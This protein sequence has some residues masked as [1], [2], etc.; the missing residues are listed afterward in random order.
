MT[1]VAQT[2]SLLPRVELMTVTPAMATNWLE[3]A[4]T[5]NRKL[6]DAYV[7]RLARDIA[8]GRWLLT[9]EGLAFDPT[10]VLLDGQHRLWAVV[11][12]DK[13]IQTYVWLNITPDALVAINN[14]RPRSIQDALTLAGGMG[15]VTTDEMATLRALLGGLGSPPKL[16]SG[17]AREALVRHRAAVAF[18]IA[19][20]S[21]SC[22]TPGVVTANTRAAVARA[23][24]TQDRARVAEFSK[25]LVTGIAPDAS[26]GIVLLLRNALARN[27]GGSHVDRCARYALTERALKAFLTGERL[28]RLYPA[29]IELF[30]LPDE[31][32]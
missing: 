21:R 31:T 28:A 16:T 25:M 7:S 15:P 1:A 17:E 27:V 23:W 8:E 20:L 4:N 32:P 13:P 29:S 5:R 2:G 9:H 30:P 6:S 3:N 19:S 14:G 24:Y 10:G 22:P 26:A 11:L 12:A 18:A